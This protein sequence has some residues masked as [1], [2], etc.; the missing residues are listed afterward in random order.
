MDGLLPQNLFNQ[1]RPCTRPSMD[2]GVVRVGCSGREPSGSPAG[3]SWLRRRS[4]H[5][6]AAARSSR[7]R[8]PPAAGAQRSGAPKRGRPLCRLGWDFYGD[9][10][11]TMIHHDSLLFGAGCDRHGRRLGIRSW[12]EQVSHIQSNPGTIDQAPS[13]WWCFRSM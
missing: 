4:A 8:R 3:S 2:P 13:V 1:P 11:S 7:Q 10:R 5:S 6:V 12:H 9:R